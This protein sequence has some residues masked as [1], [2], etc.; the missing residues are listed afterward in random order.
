MKRFDKKGMLIIPNPMQKKALEHPKVY[1]IRE[2]FCPNGHD[3]VSDRAVFGDYC[4][5]VIK[6]R[7]GGREGL[8]ALSPLYG[9][10]SRVAIDIELVSGETLEIL[11]PHCDIELPVYSHCGCGADLVAFFLAPEPD[12]AHCIGV[13]NRVDCINAQIIKSG[14][15]VS[16]AMIDAL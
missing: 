8:V 15:L 1:V 13:C 16:L 2:L 14:E 4:G 12:F 10:K 5:I 9:E 11:C 7:Q 6:A 3:L